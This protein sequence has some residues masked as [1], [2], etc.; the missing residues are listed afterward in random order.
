MLH[1]AGDGRAVKTVT[2][3][4]VWHDMDTT[5]AKT[6]GDNIR[7]ADDAEAIAELISPAAAAEAYDQIEDD[8]TAAKAQ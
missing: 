7:D 5:V 4:G 6:L 8:E 3:G 2:E 1:A